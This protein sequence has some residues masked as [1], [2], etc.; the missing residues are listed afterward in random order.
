MGHADGPLSSHDNINFIACMWPWVASAL[1]SC[2][3][4]LTILIPTFPQIALQYNDHE[5]RIAAVGKNK[6]VNEWSKH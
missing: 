5:C 2:V 4:L 1:Y 3:C 6:S